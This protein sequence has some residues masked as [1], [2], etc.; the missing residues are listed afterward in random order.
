MQ[1]AVN[2]KK[3]FTINYS[4]QINLP[5]RSQLDNYTQ[6][7]S[8]NSIF[9]GNIDLDKAIT[10]T[11][12]L[13][14]SDYNIP[15]KYSWYSNNNLQINE[16]GFSSDYLFN[17]INTFSTPIL[18]DNQRISFSTRN[19]FFYLFKNFEAGVDVNLSKTKQN[20]IIN[21]LQEIISDKLSVF[22]NIK[23]TFKNLPELSFSPYLKVYQQKN[24]D[25]KSVT[26]NIGYKSKIQH[27]FLKQ[28][29]AN[30]SYEHS[31]FESLKAFNTLNFELRFTNKIKSLDIS[32]VGI[33]AL[34]SKVNSSISQFSLSLTETSKITLGRRILLKLNYN[35]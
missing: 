14:Y 35:F 1:Y 33:N 28:Y 8:Y 16:K 17:D 32:V 10:H 31:K 30:I 24:N 2:D 4:K 18:I 22:P 15:K 29:Y 26:K 20:L 12:S 7:S 23:T 21:G 27:S 19:S 25:I 13:S 11:F 9:K 34:S 3:K 5:Y 6:I